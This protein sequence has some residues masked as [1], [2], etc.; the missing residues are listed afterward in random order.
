MNKPILTDDNYYDDNFYMSTSRFKNYMMCESKAL[1][2]DN[3]AWEDEEETPKHLIVGNYYH[4][5]FEDQKVHEKFVEDHRDVIFKKDG[6]KYA[7]F[8]KADIGIEALKDEEVFKQYYDGEA[9]DRVVKELIVTGNLGGID[10]KGKIDSINL[11]KGYFVDLK[12]MQA[13]HGKEQYSP[14]LKQRVPQVVYNIYEYYYHLQMYVYQQLLIQQE[15]D[16]FTPYIMAVSKEDIPDK[17]LI[18]IDDELLEQGQQVFEAH[19]ERV[20]GVFLGLVP[21]RS[22]GKCDWCRHKKKI[23]RPIS[24]LEILMNEQVD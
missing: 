16:F 19:I 9:G 20:K 7:D 22:C 2:I 3:G 10:F 21:P 14:L 24:L 5:Y 8:V 12:T 17:E 11:T 15:G 13:I 4:T 6:K 1:A 23:V 18:V